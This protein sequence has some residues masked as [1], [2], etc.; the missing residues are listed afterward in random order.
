M[1]K[2]SKVTLRKRPIAKGKKQSYFLDIYPPIVHPVKGTPVRHYSLNVVIATRPQNQSERNINQTL[3]SKALDE[4]ARI[5]IMVTGGDFSFLGTAQSQVD[6]ISYCKQRM[7]VR[8]M[9]LTQRT[10][11]SYGTLIGHLVKYRKTIPMNEVDHNLINDFQKF[12]LNRGLSATSI[13][14]YVVILKSIIEDAYAEDKVQPLKKRLIVDLIIKPKSKQK[15]TEREIANL[16][17]ADCQIPDV[18]RACLL[19]LSTG[20]RIGDVLKLRYS[21]VKLNEGRD[22]YYL[23]IVVQKTNT[24]QHIWLNNEGLYLVGNR[25]PTNRVF[26]ILYGRSFSKYL[27]LWVDAAGI[28]WNVTAHIFRHTALD[29][30]ANREGQ[31]LDVAQRIGT[32]SQIS[33]TQIYANTDTT[34]IIDAVNN[35]T[36]GII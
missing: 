20:L 13:R 7:T 36:F 34:R 29:L 1:T 2:I 16:V 17:Q 25:K 14:H 12:L 28:D 5:T 21:D 10:L 19:S 24:P 3:K 35:H 23:D 4:A 30:H 6:L 22:Q 26:E 31:G 18:K 9:K 15:L 32:H 8:S 33:T 27:S 11:A